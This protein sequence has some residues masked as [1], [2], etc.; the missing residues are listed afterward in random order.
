MAYFPNGESGRTFQAAECSDCIHE[1]GPD[2]KS[3]CYVY[4]VHL[5]HNYDQL[6]NEE[7]RKALTILI[8]DEKPLGSMCSMW[9]QQRGGER[10]GEGS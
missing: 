9:V 10:A 1:D 3:G 5:L 8:D 6:R 2:H 4:L 7:L